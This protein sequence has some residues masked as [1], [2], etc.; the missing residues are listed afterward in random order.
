MARDHDDQ[1]ATIEAGLNR[2]VH[3][4]DRP[5]ADLSDRVSRATWSDR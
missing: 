1:R 4:L 2:L 3:E 5:P